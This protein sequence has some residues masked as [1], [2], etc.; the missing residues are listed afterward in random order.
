VGFRITTTAATPLYIQEIGMRGYITKGKTGLA[1]FGIVVF[2]SFIIFPAI[3][4]FIGSL[5]SAA[6]IWMTQLPA[7]ITFSNYHKI[8]TVSTV[9]IPKSIM[10]SLIVSVMA[11]FIVL[12]VGAPAAY[13]VSRYV[14]VSLAVYA[15]LILIL[16]ERAVPPM[17]N[18]ISYYLLMRKLHL[19]NTLP[20]IV[21][22][23]VSGNLPFALLLL[24][25]YLQG[26]P[27]ELEEAALVDGC[28]VV[29]ALLRIVFPLAMP[30]LA[31][32]TIFI[33]IM[34]WNE[35]YYASIL[36]TNRNV[37][38]LPVAISMFAG[39]HRLQWGSITAAGVLA[40]IP[41]LVFACLVQR[42]IVS[43]LTMGA[44]R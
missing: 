8:L 38:T 24:S 22:T 1:Y 21:V 35:F 27:K 32:V 34:S 20:G 30:G 36:L 41:A 11:A 28:T 18:V 17:C 5:S 40:M 3:W 43:G 42:K 13:V 10:N 44:V 26:I 15:F 39:A 23:Y 33:F 12:L 4:C 16:I 7:H 9:N 6:D 37:Q 31:V 25:P 2:I 19:V 14:G 29:Q